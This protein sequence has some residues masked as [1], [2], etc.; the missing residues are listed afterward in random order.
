MKFNLFSRR[1]TRR[2][3]ARKPIARAAAQAIETLEGRSMFSFGVPVASAAGASPVDMIS[4]DLNHDGRADVVTTNGNGTVVA[5]LGK[6]DATFQAPI[7]TTITVVPGARYSG[8]QAGTLATAD[9]NG[10]GNADVTTL[11]GTS[12]VTLLG[13]G[14][15]TFAAPITAAASTSPV[16]ITVGDLN[17]DGRVDLASANLDGTV[18]TML[19]NGSGSFAAPVSF[20]SGPDTEDVAIRDLNHDGHADLIATDVVSNG[21]IVVLM[22][23]GD[24]TFDAYKSYAGGS[25]PF[26]MN[27]DDYNHDGNDD[28]AVANSYTSSMVSIA[29]GNGDGT[30]GQYHSYDT[31]GQPYELESADVDGDGFDDLVTSKGNAYQVNLNNGDGTFAVA[32][33]SPG[34]G[35]VLAIGDYNNDGADDLAIAGIGSVGVMAN[36]VVA[37]TNVG[38]AV[39]FRIDAPTTTA[40]GATLPLSISALDAN[41]NA[42]T[43]FRGIVHLTASDLR[44]AG[45]T[46][47]FSAADAGVHAVPTGLMLYSAG[48]Q[49]LNVNGLGL[50]AGAA[51]VNV[52]AGAATRFTIASAATTVAGQDVALTLVA[53]DAYGNA[54]TNFVGTVHFTSSDARATL[55]ADYTFTAADAGTHAFGAT[56]AT[57]GYQTIRVTDPANAAAFGQTQYIIVSAAAVSSITI[58]GGGGHIGSAHSVVVTGLDRFGN[59]AT[60]YAGTIHLTSSD[61]ATLIGGDVML[62]NGYGVISATSFTLGAQTLTAVDVNNAALT[63]SETIVG[64]PGDAAKLVVTKIV[65]GPAGTVQRVTVTAYDAYGNLAA[66]YAGTVAIGSSD[67]NADRPFY[68]FGA[69]DNGTHTFSV[70]LRTA[71]T[72]SVTIADTFNPALSNTQGGLVVTALAASSVSMTPV[73]GTTAGVAQSFTVTARDIYGNVA[74]DFA[75]SV[76][77]ASSDTKAILPPTY[78]F[79]AADAG[80]HTFSMTFLGAGGQTF[81]MT[82]SLTPA[83]PYLQSDINIAAAAAV[84][85]GI[86]VPSTITAGS[87]FAA[88]VTAVDAYGNQVK[89]YSGTVH[90][91]NFTIGG[92]V[93]PADYTFTAGE[94]GSH[95]FTITPLA[96]GTAT[97]TVND[98]AK[99]TLTSS[100]SITVKAASNSKGGGGT[101]T[102][103]TPTPTPTPVP[104]SGGGGGGGG[105]S[106]GGGKKV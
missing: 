25:A 77:F 104:T 4:V 73:V 27:V 31:G 34:T 13:N 80:T 54:A 68:A 61:A 30:F 81:T 2:Q 50:A 59:L 53:S 69:A 91:S 12:V 66:D 85:F 11:S 36:D 38:A 42:V 87:A 103:P 74:K 19:G 58:A 52:V 106:G 49:T 90:L 65:G 26:R 57:S 35:N 89:N 95:T 33:S 1:D 46:F 105:G 48:A 100:T 79:A 64:T 23:H 9:F 16:R 88:T 10:D 60:G 43:D 78:T 44:T 86:K 32:T 20:A 14:D 45:Q 71:G 72:Q 75:G 83:T 96:A 40:A 97:L 76:S 92:T 3:A 84:G 15:G 56:L 63:A 5:L 37:T 55:P 41:G 62:V 21:A 7:A 24:N 18:S 28:V 6:G 70:V 101:T 98:V 17:G 29:Y 8:T 99:K 102:T 94:L 93:L 51:T 67:A 47:V 82:N 39:A 22:G